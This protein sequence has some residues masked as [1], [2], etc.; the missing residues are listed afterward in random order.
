[1]RAAWYDRQ[2]LAREAL[3][4]GEPRLFDNVTIRLLGSGATTADDDVE[5]VRGSHASR[6]LSGPKNPVID[7][8][9]PSGANTPKSTPSI[10]ID[11]SGPRSSQANRR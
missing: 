11:W 7:A 1:V 9:R 5:T 8:S 3:Q 2:G 4:V 10:T 6:G